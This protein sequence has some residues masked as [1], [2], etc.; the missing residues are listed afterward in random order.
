[1]V[2]QEIGEDTIICLKRKSGT[3]TGSIQKITNSNDNRIIDDVC[4][5]FCNFKELLQVMII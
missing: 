2:D 1:M 3:I 4:E 5:D